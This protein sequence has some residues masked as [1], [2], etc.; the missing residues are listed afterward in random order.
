[1][2]TMNAGQKRKNEDKTESIPKRRRY[3]S[4]P[5][6]PSSNPKPIY[7]IKRNLSDK[8]RSNA[9]ALSPN[10]PMKFTLT[11][12]EVVRFGRE[13]KNDLILSSTRNV[14]FR[15]KSIENNLLISRMHGKF[16]FRDDQ[17][18][19]VDN[20]STN[21]IIVNGTSITPN[22][23]HP[24][25][26]DDEIII[27]KNVTDTEFKY[28]FTSKTTPPTP[29]TPHTLVTAHPVVQTPSPLKDTPRFDGSQSQSFDA[30][31]LQN[32][33]KTMTKKMLD[34]Q[35]EQFDEK[36][37]MLD[38]QRQAEADASDALRRKLQQQQLA[39]ITAK[40]EENEKKQRELVEKAAELKRNQDEVLRKQK[41]NEQEIEQEKAR[42]AQQIATVKK[43][44]EEKQIK[45]SQKSREREEAATKKLKELE[46]QKMDIEARDKKQRELNHIE[47]QK[48]IEKQQK[49]EDEKKKIEQKERQ[50]KEKEEKVMKEKEEKQHSMEE[51]CTCCICCDLLVASRSLECGHTSCHQCLEAWMKEQKT[52]PSCRNPIK[53][54][55]VP[56][57]IVDNLIVDTYL[58]DK[59]EE[60]REEYMERKREYVIWKK[61]H[62]EEEAAAKQRQMNSHNNRRAVIPPSQGG[63]HAMWA[64]NNIQNIAVRSI[65]ANNRNNNRVPLPFG[66]VR[67]PLQPQQAPHGIARNNA[68]NMRFNPN[69]HNRMM[70]QRVLPPPPPPLP[71]VINANNRNA[72]VRHNNQ[73]NNAFYRRM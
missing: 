59:S 22:E 31:Q 32:M 18:Y 12:R 69:I 16:M 66:A 60:D 27:G 58:K 10:I 24:L 41:E 72:R 62:K 70:M 36:F 65:D 8:E 25:D 35:Q 5:P 49:L 9:L 47:H 56:C 17:W 21:G 48:W 73:N 40:E 7:I 44:L 63:N 11:K 23:Q 61:K 29:R 71:P 2:P 45:E 26:I 53:Q 50:I 55:P 1:M 67:I 6:P 57:I 28:I 54:A 13:T 3:A 52:C 19:I 42:N 33:F 68:N 4:P 64:N 34:Q 51:E 38:Q 39:E 30:A 15:D 20:N 14:L 37:K 43:K 46:K